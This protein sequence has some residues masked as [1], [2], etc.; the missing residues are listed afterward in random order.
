MGEGLVFPA[1]MSRFT[2]CLA[3]KNAAA[4]SEGLRAEEFACV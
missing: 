4:F 2:F 3:I 1:V